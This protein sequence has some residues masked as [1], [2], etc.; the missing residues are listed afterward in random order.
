LYQA[1]WYVDSTFS[2]LMTLS[3]VGSNGGEPVFD[4][5][6]FTGYI[7]NCQEGTIRQ[8]PSGTI[9]FFFYTGVDSASH[10]LPGA[11]ETAGVPVASGPWTAVVDS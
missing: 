11:P 3:I 8:P 10:L 2:G 6:V 1:G 9:D 7:V 5:A 4:C